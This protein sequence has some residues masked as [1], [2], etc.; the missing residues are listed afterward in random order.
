[1]YNPRDEE[2]IMRIKDRTEVFDEIVKNYPT[3]LGKQPC[4]ICLLWILIFTVF[5]NL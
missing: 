2:I 3:S 4:S 5:A 1:M